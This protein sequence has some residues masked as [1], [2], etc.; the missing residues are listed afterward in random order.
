MDGKEAEYE[1]GDDEQR[2]MFLAIQC[3]PRPVY[4]LTHQTRC[5]KGGRRLK[6]DPETTPI[7][8]EGLEMIGKCLVLAAVLLVLVGVLEHGRVQLANVIL[9]ERNL[10]PRV[11]D[12]LHHFSVAGDLCF[13]SRSKRTGVQPGQ[14]VL[15]FI[16]GQMGT[17][18]PR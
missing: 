10:G 5:I 4:E 17:F 1:D 15:D 16:I 18:D 12:K 11:E 9:V 6:N 8:G 14:Q 3:C 2:V 13:V 7:I